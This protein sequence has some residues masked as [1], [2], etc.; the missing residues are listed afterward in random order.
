[1]PE[2]RTEALMAE[3][4]PTIVRFDMDGQVWPLEFVAGEAHVDH[5]VRVWYTERRTGI[6][7]EVW[8]NLA[9][10]FE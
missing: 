5:K 7:N 3:V 2:L 1:M 6:R 4:T 9:M 10:L 8:M